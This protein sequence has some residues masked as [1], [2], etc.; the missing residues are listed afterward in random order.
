[1]RRHLL[2]NVVNLIIANTVLDL[3][4]GGPDRD[5][6]RLHRPGRS[7]PAVVGPDPQRRP[8]GRRAEPRGVV[9]GRR[10]GQLPGRRRPGVHPRRE[11]PRR[12]PQPARAGSAMSGPVDP[13]RL[14]ESVEAT[15]RAAEELDEERELLGSEA[16]AR[17]AYEAS[18][19]RRCMRAGRRRGALHR[20][21]PRPT[22]RVAQ[23][24]AAGASGRFPSRPIPTR[25]SS[26]SRTSRPTSRS[27]RGRSRAVD[28]VSFTLDD[29]E[30]LGIAGESG[31]GK[32]T[33]A[34]SLVRL[35]PSNARIV[36]GSIKLFGIDLVPK[37]ENALRRYRWREISIVFQG[38]MNA[39]NPVRRVGDQIA[40]PLEERLGDRGR[41]GTQAG[42]RAARAGR[43][44]EGA[45]AGLPAR[46]V[47]RD[48]PAGDDRDGPGLRPGDRHRRRADDRARR[49]GPGPDPRTAR[50]PARATRPVAHPHHPRPVGHRRDVRPG[51]HHVRRPDRRG[52]PGR[53]GLPPAAPSVHAEAA[54]RLPEHP[55]RPADARR[56]PGLAARPA[57]PTARL[58]VRAAL[59]VRD[60]G[61]HAR[62]CRRRSRFDAVRVACHLYPEGSDGVPVT[63]P[64]AD[65]IGETVVVSVG[66]RERA[67]G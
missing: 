29:G 58:P 43:H 56:H 14:V 33:T 51:P 5:D 37:S 11:R 53:G 3:R 41:R 27:N 2:P 8:D 67:P 62:S 63:T 25:R 26:S 9:V 38:A 34:L 7:V 10:P 19:S 66:G 47:G 30:A 22:P 64:T 1:M 49:H 31:C 44:P 39:L 23:R 42:G 28:G 48:A 24:S 20:G 40:E 61:L 32:T 55:C 54:G 21:V 60:G 46:A 59:L 52:R 50:G 17:A 12:H 57:Q 15:E 16:E 18:P 6:P 4:R 65:A 36:E 35:L 45:P 13:R